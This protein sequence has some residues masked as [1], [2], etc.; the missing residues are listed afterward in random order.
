ML[1]IVKLF[2]GI[3]KYNP[4]IDGA[5][6]ASATPKKMSANDFFAQR[7]AARKESALASKLAA[8]KYLA[9]RKNRQQTIQ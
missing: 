7:K 9:A 5:F 8:Q 4:R 6:I 2:E 1:S 3:N